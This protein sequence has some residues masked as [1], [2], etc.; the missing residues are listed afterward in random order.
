MSLTARVL[1][2]LVAGFALG[3]VVSGSDAG[4]LRA[5]PGVLDPVGA[6]WVN[7]IR[8]TVIP[9]VVASLV[10]AVA[11]APDPRTIG[12]I[13]LRAF[14]A[15]VLVVLAAG[16][17]SAMVGPPLVGLLAIDPAAAAAL[18]EHAVAAGSASTRVIEPPTLA[19]W[20]VSLVPANPVAAASDG[21]LLPLIVAALAFGAAASRVP[22]EGRE[23]LVRVVTAARDASIVLVRWLLV[24]APVGVFALAVGLSARLGVA[25]LGA[26]AGYV[27]LVCGL[28]AA[29]SLLALYPLAAIAGRVGFRAFARAALPAQAVA[30]SSRSS[31]A[32]LTA[33]VEAAGRT[34]RLGD[35]ISGFFVPLAASTFRTG[36]AVGQVI[37]ALFLARLYGVDIGATALA[38]MVLTTVI[39]CFS[40]PGIPGG[41]I[42][43]MVPVLQAAGIPVA[44]VGILLGVDTIPDMF[45]TTTNVTGDLA[46]ATVLA[47][48]PGAPPEAGAR[49]AAAA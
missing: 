2:G 34:L 7:G 23:A 12:R 48:R 42:I 8:M 27:A 49:G 46:V 45:R 16:I 33:M 24:L 31:M 40:V 29:F 20:L 19:Q 28:S 25:D 15:F 21:A 22:A 35:E 5:I 43:T 3:L 41:A 6:I 38:A 1:A 39:T 11:G 37:G 17:V 30:F 4:W 10:V 18:R 36:G 44:G 26:V 32:A 9:L 13:G 14:V 47:P